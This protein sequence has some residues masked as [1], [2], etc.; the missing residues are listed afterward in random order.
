METLDN[1]KRMI[2]M[3]FKRVREHIN[4]LESRA[5]NMDTSNP[6]TIDYDDMVEELERQFENIRLLRKVLKNDAY[7]RGFNHKDIIQPL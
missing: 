1:K 7:I 6:E 4:L 2:E 5:R 3:W